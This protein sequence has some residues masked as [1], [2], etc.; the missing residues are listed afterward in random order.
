MDIDAIHKGKGKYNGYDGYKRKGKGKGKNKGKGYGGYNGYGYNSYNTNYK[1]KGKYGGKGFNNYNNSPIGF[2]NPFG[3]GNKETKDSAK[4]TTKAKERTK[5]NKRQIH[6]TD[7][8]EQDTMPKIAEW[9]YT[10][11]DKEKAMTMRTRQHNGTMTTMTMDGTFRTTHDNNKD[12]SHWHFRQFQ[13][14]ATMT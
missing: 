5:E 11:L 6:A 10:I 2:G 7:V 1:G 12:N 8:E 4:D 9:Q 14:Q 13:P 3:R